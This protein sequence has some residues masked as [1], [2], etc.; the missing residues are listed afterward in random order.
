MAREG[1]TRLHAKKGEKTS[2]APFEESE[3]GGHAR[4]SISSG[5]RGGVLGY[6]GSR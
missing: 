3:R 2:G 6:R 5:M 1:D 4:A